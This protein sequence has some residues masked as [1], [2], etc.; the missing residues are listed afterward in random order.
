MPQTS[1]CPQ[2]I[3]ATDRNRFRAPRK[4]LR[5]GLEHNLESPRTQS[6][7]DF[8][9]PSLRLATNQVFRHTPIPSGAGDAPVRV[10]RLQRRYLDAGSLQRLVGKLLEVELVYRLCSSL[11]IGRIPFVL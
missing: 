5:E 10:V 7:T 8:P 2:L 6:T 11:C 1:E 3:R 9:I 4:I